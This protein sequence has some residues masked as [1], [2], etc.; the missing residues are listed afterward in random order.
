[1]EKEKRKTERKIGTWK[2]KGNKTE[3]STAMR[4]LSRTSISLRTA[5]LS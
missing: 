3:L 5:R 1:V 4:I 2:A